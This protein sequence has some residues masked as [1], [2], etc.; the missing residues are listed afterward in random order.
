MVISGRVSGLFL[1]LLSEFYVLATYVVISGWVPTCL[2]GCFGVLPP[3]NIYG[4]TRTGT[5]LV[6]LVIVGILHSDNICDYIRTSTGFVIVIG[7]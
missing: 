3:G 1:W 6:P 4:N 5:G 2:F 7:V